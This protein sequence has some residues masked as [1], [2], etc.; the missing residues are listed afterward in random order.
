MLILEKEEKMRS[1]DSGRQSGQL[2]FNSVANNL[3]RIGPKQLQQQVIEKGRSD[4]T[5]K[6]I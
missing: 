2:R 4:K 6:D 1:D 5:W 3:V